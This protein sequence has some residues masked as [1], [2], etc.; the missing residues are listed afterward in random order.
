MD[1]KYDIA[2]TITPAS[3]AHLEIGFDAGYS[4]RTVTNMSFN[5]SAPVA[6][7]NWHHLS[8]PINAAMS[9]IGAVH[10]VGFYQWNPSAAGTMN[11]W[12]ANVKVIARLVPAAP[13][14]TSLTKVLPGLKQFANVAPSY[15]R[16][17]VRTDTNGAASVS[18]VGQAKPVV[19]SFKV[20]EF[21]TAALFNCGLT[22]APGDPATQTYA[23]PDWSA[24]NALWL[25]IAA[26]GDGTQQVRFAYKTNQ[27]NA[28]AMLYGAGVM[29]NFIYNGSALGTWK[30]TFTSDTA[31]TVTAPDGSTYSGSIPAD[32]AAMFA[33][34]GGFWLMSSPANDANIGQSMT[35]GALSITGTGSPINQNFTTGSL[36]PLLVLQSQVYNWNTNPANQYL[37][38]TSNGSYWNHW[39]MPDKGFTPIVKSNLTSSA[40][41][42]EV[43]SSILVNG[44]ERWA[45]VPPANMPA[46]SAGFFAM[47]KREF[48]QLQVLL[49]GQT[50]AP[51]TALGYVGTP[52]P[53]S[54]ASQGATGT[55]VTVNA[56]DS[57]WH[58]I[59]GITDTIHVTSTDGSAYTPVDMA[60][61]NGVAT[62]ADPNGLLFLSTGPQTVT[63]TDVTDGSKTPNTSAPVTINP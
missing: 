3:Q 10:S 6:D 52:T 33:G 39:T 29:T 51:G 18:W 15:G 17:V 28:N 60:M 20:T 55:T 5:T 35:F 16:Q 8:I 40:W 41:S 14:T 12:V 56:C 46:G 11:F 57:Q 9:G 48:T 24:P 1:L 36:N 53:I 19:Y 37:L 27:P 13:P 54:L 2:S 42:D 50:N 43:Y 62:F 58:I 7:G 26:I 34:P 44:G 23:D 61:V 22:I 49:P 63:A 47:I 25:N 38:T 21:P 59:G 31:A 30:V 45:L 4:M 32:I